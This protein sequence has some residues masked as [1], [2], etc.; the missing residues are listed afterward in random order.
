MKSLK[1]SNLEQIIFTIPGDDYTFFFFLGLKD[2]FQ[3]TQT[4]ASV[5]C[6]MGIT[7]EYQKGERD[8]INIHTI[9]TSEDVQSSVQSAAT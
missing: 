1:I 9:N 8:F 2:T 5:Y 7:M 3:A 6:G 4:A